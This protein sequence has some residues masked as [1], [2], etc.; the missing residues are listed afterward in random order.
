MDY[1]FNIYKSSEVINFRTETINVIFVL[2]GDMTLFQNNIIHSYKKHS[3]FLIKPYQTMDFVLKFQK[4]I[5]LSINALSFNRF[6]LFNWEADLEN[7]TID[8]AIIHTYLN[9]IKSLYEK[10]K[11]NADINVV[12]LINY[13]RLSNTYKNNPFLKEH[14][15]LKEIIAYIDCNYKKSLTVS[16]IANEF[17]VNTSYLSRLFSN[18][19]NISLLAYIRKIKIYHL[20]SDLISNPASKDVWKNYGYDSYETYLKHFKIVFSMSPSEFISNYKNNKST[21]NQFE[22]IN[23]LTYE[24]I[25]KLLN[26]K[27]FNI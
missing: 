4:I 12:K 8:N 22:D 13:I 9:V 16:A 2:E 5:V 27:Q 6:A 24:E 21:T 25:K 3:F 1:T 7:T 15:L 10:D 20:A 14:P 19:M 18:N 17:Y 11:F 23:S 26:T